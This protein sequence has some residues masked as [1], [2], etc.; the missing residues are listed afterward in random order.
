MTASD[1]RVMRHPFKT[2]GQLADILG[3]YG[4]VYSLLESGV[5]AKDMPDE[6]IR[7]AW[8]GMQHIW[9]AFVWHA[10]RIEKML[11]ESQHREL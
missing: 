9:R 10:D 7:D 11:H 8:E 3:D 5:T 2:R 6:E 1:V 4:N